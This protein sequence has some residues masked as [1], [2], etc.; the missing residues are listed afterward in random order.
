MAYLERHRKLEDGTE[1]L[2]SQYHNALKNIQN[3]NVETFD[4]EKNNIGNTLKCLTQ[5]VFSYWGSC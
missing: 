3:I 2:R 1:A 4:L 5:E